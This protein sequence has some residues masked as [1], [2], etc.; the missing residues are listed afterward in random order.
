MLQRNVAGR[1]TEDDEERGV[2][3][4]GVTHSPVHGG[5][6]DVEI[7][8][9]Y[10]GLQH[11]DDF[12]IQA[13]QHGVCVDIDEE[14]VPDIYKCDECEPRSMKLTKEE[15]YN[16]QSKKLARQHR[17]A[18][19]KHRTE[20]KVEQRRSS[21]DASV[22]ETLRETGGISLMFVAHNIQGLVATRVFRPDEPVLYFCGRISLA[23][24]CSGRDEGMVMPFV[25]LYSDLVIDG[26]DEHTPICVDAR[27]F[28]SVA[29]FARPSC[30]PNIKLR[31]L[32]VQGRLHIIGVAAHRIESAIEVG[33]IFYSFLSKKTC[34][35]TVP[36]DG[37]YMMSKTK[38]VCACHD[39][40][41]DEVNQCIIESFNKSLEQK[42]DS[43]KLEIMTFRAESVKPKRVAGGKRI[44]TC[45]T[46]TSE[47]AS[48]AEEPQK[49]ETSTNKDMSGTHVLRRKETVAA[50]DEAITTRI[51]VKKEKQLSPAPRNESAK[52][53][54]CASK[55]PA[56]LPKNEKMKSVERRSEMN[57]KSECKKPKA[58]VS[59]TAELPM[60]RRTVSSAD[61]FGEK[62]DDI[63]AAEKLPSKST[64]A[65][66]EPEA[67]NSAAPL[68]QNRPMS[69]EERKLQ[70]QIDLFERMQQ[71]DAK[72]Q[73]L[74]AL[75]RKRSTSTGRACRASASAHGPSTVKSKKKQSVKGKSHRKRL[76][77]KK[78]ERKQSQKQATS[79]V[80]S[81]RSSIVDASATAQQATALSKEN[82]SEQQQHQQN[83]SKFS[84]KT[85]NFE[86]ALIIL[87]LNAKH[88]VHQLR[89][90]ITGF[91]E[92]A[93]DGIKSA[94][95]STG[96]E[97]TVKRMKGCREK[98]DTEAQGNAVCAVTSS[99]VE[100]AVHVSTLIRE[101]MGMPFVHTPNDFELGFEK[102]KQAE[103]PSTSASDSSHINQKPTKKVLSL[104]EY[105]KRK[106][107]NVAA[108]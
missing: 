30:R 101:L 34:H 98:S 17:R 69:R 2:Q 100:N 22:L 79:T 39:D 15:A 82:E 40:E 55:V 95:S 37:D 81:K 43:E 107:T 92:V 49:A 6:E 21:G 75:A 47:A 13:W 3:E 25:I 78:S 84:A 104:E 7:T 63:S 52:Q 97:P 26:K 59:S 66:M 4:L 93:Q 76:V 70:Q 18:A 58:S 36:F 56:D 67:T 27:Q 108:K 80:V 38:L 28:G 83:E 10:C 86:G 5:G 23:T 90:F 68:D 103:L 29:R 96:M 71:R 24:E 89:L 64:R 1:E 85:E 35:L 65:A 60:R 54:G 32:F 12:M 42:H 46:A 87:F 99:A 51:Q 88:C 50:Q 19:C 9:C 72:R 57:Y 62:I 20:Q 53:D 14:D 33:A 31:H 8:R 44:K 102:Q 73:K 106:G 94:D 74:V 48:C 91:S 61:E 11:N 41:C 77:P 105:K 16:L 45:D